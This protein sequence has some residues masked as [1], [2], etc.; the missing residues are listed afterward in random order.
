MLALK[1][2][3]FGYLAIIYKNSLFV[4]YDIISSDA[5]PLIAKINIS[6]KKYEN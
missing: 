2:L 1:D 4:Q 5:N 6:D 3:F